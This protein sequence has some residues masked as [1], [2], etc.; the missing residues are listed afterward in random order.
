VEKPER[1]TP[2]GLPRRRSKNNI[3]ME[4]EELESEGIDWIYLAQERDRWRAL[5]NEVMKI[6]VP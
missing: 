2:L 6:P 4:L 5:V 3:K 1:M